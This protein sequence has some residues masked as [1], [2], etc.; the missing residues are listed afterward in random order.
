VNDGKEVEVKSHQIMK[1][2]LCYDNV[3]NIPSPRTKERK[4]LI[5][6]YKTFGIIFKKKHVNVN[7]YMI[8]Y[9]KSMV[10]LLL[11]L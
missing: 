2:I 10:F 4:S 8:H 1:C 6:Y 7:H 11:T 9:Y 3:V 5:T